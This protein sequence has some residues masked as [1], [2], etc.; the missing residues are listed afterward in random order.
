[1]V[2]VL[3]IFRAH[4]SIDITMGFVCA[5]YFWILVQ[6]QTVKIDAWCGRA[7]RLLRG[8]GNDSTAW[9]KSIS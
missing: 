4:Y 8:P 9:Q 6:W 3:L 1:M 2:I 7:L 5:Q